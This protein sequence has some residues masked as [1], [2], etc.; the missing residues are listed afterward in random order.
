MVRKRYLTAAAA[1]CA[2]LLAG[3]AQ[4][5]RTETT[6]GAFAP[7]ALVSSEASAAETFV[8]VSRMELRYAEGFTVEYDADGRALVT[9]SGTDRYLVV[10]EGVAPR[11]APGAATLVLPLRAIYL[12]DSSAMDL[13]A[14]LDALGAIRLTSTKESDWT[15]E[16]VRREMAEGR[17]LYAG[18]YSAPDYELLL[19]EGTTLAIENS[20]IYHSP[21]TK[22]QLETL[23]IPVLVSQ[24][25]YES[26]P[27]GRLEWIKLYGLLAGKTAEA[28]AFFNAQSAR[29]EAAAAEES[30][31]KTAA[32]FYLSTNG[33]VNVRRPTDYIAKMIALAGGRY[34][35]P[36]EGA[37]DARSTMTMQPEAFYALAKDADILFYNATV[38]GGIET[39]EQLLARAEWLSDCKAVQSGDVWCTEQDLF[40][41]TSGFAEMIEEFHRIF[42]G[43]A[44]TGEPLRYFHKL[45]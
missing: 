29:A 20:M 13:F 18:K 36:D 25:S 6:D 34:A 41:Q 32:F 35:I 21:E 2:L 39:V 17:I 8:P 3:C 11:E 44:E 23:G 24:S 15:M 1:L 14:R 30:T 37:E 38:G 9:I 7:P 45:H 10:P 31:G 42:S 40:Q 5:A 19:S 4:P 28:E 26:H 16:D 27:L 22:E 12:A 33:G 43:T